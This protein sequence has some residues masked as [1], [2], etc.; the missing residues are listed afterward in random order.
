MEGHILLKK[1]T[2]KS[3]IQAGKNKGLTVGDVLQIR[4]ID[5][6]YSYFN[7]DGLTFTDEILDKLKIYPEDRIQK[8]GK[9]PE[10]FKVY[11]ERNIYI[12]SKI[13]ASKNIN[14]NTT[15]QDPKIIA[16]IVKK[17][18]QKAAFRAKYKRLIETEKRSFSKARLQRKNHGY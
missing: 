4:K 15:I 17:N 8:P 13:I 7:Y 6:I 16:G 9:E 1:L 5:L 2:E 11:A 14:E 10:K 3:V 12:A 18:R